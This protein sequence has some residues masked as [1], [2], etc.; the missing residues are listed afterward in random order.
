MF[1]GFCPQI[2]RADCTPH[3][4]SYNGLQYPWILVFTGSYSS[5]AYWL[6]GQ[7]RW[8]SR[9]LENSPMPGLALGFTTEWGQTKVWKVFS[10]VAE[11]S[12]DQSEQT[13]VLNKDVEWDL[14]SG[15]DEGGHRNAKLWKIMQWNGE[16]N[17]GQTR[18]LG[19]K[20]PEGNSIELVLDQSRN[21][22]GNVLQTQSLGNNPKFLIEEI[23]LPQ[24]RAQEICLNLCS[25]RDL[26]A[27]GWSSYHRKRG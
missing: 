6:Q 20:K 25:L 26:G 11:W 22:L 7:G 18:K 23:I 4:Y 2:Q 14:Q 10:S 9:W 19:P 5:R 24:R 15:E 17:H 3:L 13:S 8:R 1:L 21:M 12:F 16:R 27:G